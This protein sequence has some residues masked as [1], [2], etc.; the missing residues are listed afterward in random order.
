MSENMEKLK[1]WMKIIPLWIIVFLLFLLVLQNR[2]KLEVPHTQAGF[3][4]KLDTFTGDVYV[5][6]GPGQEG[7][8]IWQKMQD[9]P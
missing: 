9:A 5:A 8:E 7:R 3:V 6:Y 4:Y 1:F 2:W